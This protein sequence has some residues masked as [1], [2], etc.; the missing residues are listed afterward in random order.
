MGSCIADRLRMDFAEGR[1]ECWLAQ[2]MC[3]FLM[4]KTNFVK[5]KN[6]NY[7]I[8]K[9]NQKNSKSLEVRRKYCWNFENKGKTRLVELLPVGQ[10]ELQPVQQLE[11]SDQNHL[12]YKL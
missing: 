8:L 7:L 9:K 6:L 11:H 1:E 3:Q 10:L 12:E 5:R 4:K 2:S